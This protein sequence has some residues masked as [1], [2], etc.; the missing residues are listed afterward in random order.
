MMAQRRSASTKVNITWRESWCSSLQVGFASRA[1]EAKVSELL[2]AGITT[3]V[4]ITG[5]D[6]VTR[7]QVRRRLHSGCVIPA[8]AAMC[9]TA[10]ASNGRCW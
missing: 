9:C 4:G 2:A 5:T 3:L 6:S 1:P 8:V 7:S 10:R